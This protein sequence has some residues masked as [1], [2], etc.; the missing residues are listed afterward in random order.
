MRRSHVFINCPF[1]AAFK[2]I[3]EAI[4]F[5]VYDLGF[6][7]RCALELDDS[8]AVRLT[9][10]ERIIEQCALGIHD[11]SNVTLDPGTGLPRFNMPFELGMFLGCRRFGGG[12]HSRKACLIL[13]AE[14][15][16][17]QKYISDIAGQDI[18]SHGGDPDK[19]IV[20]VRNWL[21]G[22]LKHKGLPGGA[23]IVERY[24]RFRNDLRRLCAPL[25]REPEKLTFVDLS[26]T[27]KEWLRDNP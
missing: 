16:R 24:G 12:T 27:I 26:E 10:I 13:E 17:Y 6:V 9:K 19:A 22:T 4:V 15:Y 21:S 1:D 14:Q 2:P 23:L 18:H 8:G 25:H 20:E 5:A 3:L 7:P 11:I